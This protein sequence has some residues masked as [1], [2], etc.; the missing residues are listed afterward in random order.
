MK[1]RLVSLCLILCLVLS[2]LAFASCGSKTPA[3]T[4]PATEGSG[5]TDGETVA[6][7]TDKWDVLAPKITMLAAAPRQLRIECSSNKSAEKASRNDIYLK[8][9][10]TIVEGT[11]PLIQVMVYE[12]NKAANDLLGTS[13]EF[14]FWDDPWGQQAQRIDLVVKG[15]AADAP[16]LFVNMLNELNLELLNAAFKDIWTIPNS[17]FD[18]KTEGWLETWM[19][20]LSFTGDRAYILGGDYFLDVFRALAVLP[21]NMTLM[22][23]NAEKLA[24]AIIGTDE[25]L[26]AGENLTTRFFDF[27]ENGRWTWDVL[28]KLCELAW[29]DLDNDGQDSIY[30]IL[31][32]I[33][34]EYGDGGQC[35][36]SFIYSCGE[37]LTEAYTIEDPSSEYYEKQWIKY[38]DDSS[39][40]NRIFDAVKKVFEGP[41][42]Y[43]TFYTFSGNEPDKPGI[44]YHHTKF[45]ASE[46]L[47]TGVC[48]LGNLEDEVFQ[49]M[50]D[51]YSVV[52]CPKLD[53]TKEYNTIIYSTGDAGAINV[54]AN[55][56]KLKALTAYI[57]YCTENSPPIR[58]QFLQIVMK[59]KATVY[60]QGTDRMLDIIYESIRYGRDKT[61]DDL[62][63]N[64]ANR[65][66]GVMRKE[67][68]LAGSEYISQQY[69]SLLSLKKYHLDKDLQTWYTLPTVESNGSAG[70]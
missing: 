20:N 47:F 12:R 10:D 33:A 70:N 38:A 44:A 46:L 36:G 17:F 49:N 1:K 22:D 59:Y 39:G 4:E 28:G 62:A 25:T 68:F 35:S 67:H 18:F 6:A 31:G 41:G 64:S 27:V 53:E 65:W 13:T 55:P 2:V 60:D 23:K 32:I 40:L 30:D 8:G 14:V 19:R 37:A 29:V 63:G 58:E 52:P 66:H 5:A 61:V 24:P 16:D 15:G 54:N 45:A 21:F 7:T 34:D 69:Q 42:S 9:P 56:V 57:Q 50:M 43:S 26:G 11:T 51:L 3:A 48:L